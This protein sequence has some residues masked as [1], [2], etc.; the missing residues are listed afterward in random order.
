MQRAATFLGSSIG[1]KV[2]MAATGL[3][4]YGFVIGHMVGNLQIYLGPKAIN[5]YAEFLQHFLHGQGIW[6]A[7]GSL[8]VAVGLHV[9]AAVTLTLSN[10]S[11]RPWAIA[12]GR[13]ASPP[14]RRARWYG[15]APSWPPSSSTTFSTSRWA[16]STRSS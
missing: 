15:A 4:L 9:W 13:H 2:V 3:V 5:D 1:K 8:L 7:R 10:W 11:A 14:T 12:T 6:L 16:A